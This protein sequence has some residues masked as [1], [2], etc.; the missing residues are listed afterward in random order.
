MFVFKQQHTE[1]LDMLSNKSASLFS[2]AIG[3]C[4]EDRTMYRGKGIGINFRS[5]YTNDC[6][7]LNTQRFPD[8]LQN[9]VSRG[10]NDQAVEGDVVTNLFQEIAVLRFLFHGSD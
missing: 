1:V 4:I 7:S 10:L 8:L 9:P 3:E 6:T 2:I 5:E